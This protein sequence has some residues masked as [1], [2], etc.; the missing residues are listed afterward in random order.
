MA[1]LDDIKQIQKL[2]KSNMAG[3]ILEMPKQ[4]KESLEKVKKIDLPEDWKK[5]NKVCMVGMGGSAIANHLVA[6]LPFSERRLP[7]YVVRNY[8]VPDWVDENTLVIITS[9]SG[10]T[11]E[12][13]SAFKSI[14]KKEPIRKN[15]KNLP[16]SVGGLTK[17]FIIAERGQL[18]ELG[19]NAGAIIFDYDTQ[20]PPRASL[21][22]QLGAVFGLLNKL[23]IIDQKLKPAIELIEKINSDFEP[24]VKSDDPQSDPTELRGNIAK[25]LAFCCLDRLP[26]IVGS[27]ILQSV[28]WRWKTQ[29][30]ENAN[31]LAFTEFL[32]EAMHNAIQGQD[33]PK[34]TQESLIYVILKNSSD[35]QEL[36][37]QFKKFENVLEDKKIRYEIIESLGDDIFSQ[38]LSTLIL[39]DWVSYYLAML[40]GVDPTPVE[41]IERSKGA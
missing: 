18:E 28:A 23:K 4:I 27:G 25:N 41:T 35:S 14:I 36:V 21:G 33:F 19:K 15:V 13:L 38:K 24:N 9:H 30:N 2:D 12:T 7:M 10:R 40:N 16:D 5:V 22:Y 11:Q 31:Q 6:N 37:L 17:I 3:F 34:S 39:G 32:P 1:T 26:V 8:T 20:A 29:M